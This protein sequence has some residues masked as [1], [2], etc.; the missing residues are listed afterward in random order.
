VAS[1]PFDGVEEEWSKRGLSE[2]KNYFNLLTR[3]RILLPTFPALL[4]PNTFR[5]QRNNFAY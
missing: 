4:L 3:T 5:A 2:T 1:Y